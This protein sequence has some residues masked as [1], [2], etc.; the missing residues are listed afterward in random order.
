M[1]KLLIVMLL[2]L[3]ATSALAQDGKP[4]QVSLIPDIAIYPKDTYIKGIM[5]NVWGENPNTGFAL[6]LVNGAT[7]DSLGCSL[8]LFNYAQNYTGVE[9]GWVNFAS[10]NFVGWQNG[11]FNYAE[12]LTGLQLGTVNIA[13]SA[14]S[15]LQIGLVNIM[16]DNEWF[17]G[18]P[19]Q[20]AKGMVFVNWS[21]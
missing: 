18:F 6:G 20:L 2:C 17:T 1:K 11:I 7:G 4:F 9:W 13:Q 15:G 12:K 3:V 10:G 14:Q 8:G 19:K 21:F 16:M 5:L